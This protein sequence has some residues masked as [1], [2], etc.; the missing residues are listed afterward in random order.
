MIR[1]NKN[2]YAHDWKPLNK[3]DH[4]VGHQS[5]FEN[6]QA[7]T[8]CLLVLSALMLCVMGVGVYVFLKFVI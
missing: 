8:G 1:P 7:G 6:L 2:G 4:F 3:E 5:E